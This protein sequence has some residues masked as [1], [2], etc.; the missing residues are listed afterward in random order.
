MGET[1]EFYDRGVKRMKRKKLLRYII[2]AIPFLFV[3]AI[4]ISATVSYYYPYH[5]IKNCLYSN[6]DEFEQLTVYV[7][8]LYTEGDRHIQIN[9]DSDREEIK[10]ILGRLREQYQKDSDFRVFSAVDVYFD[11]DGDMLFY[12]GAKNEKIKNGDGYNSPDILCYDLVYIDENYDG[13]QPVK[14]KE[15]FWGN[16]RTWSFDTYSG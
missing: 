1:G 11:N 5:Y 3:I 4:V 14:D 9:E 12:I 10:A 16:W 8:N 6:K 2:V 15:P 7:R 13:D